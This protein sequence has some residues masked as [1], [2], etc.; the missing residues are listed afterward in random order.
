MLAA[1]KG[2]KIKNL[3]AMQPNLLNS[4]LAEIKIS[5]STTVKECDRRKVTQSRE[6]VE[7]FRE[8]FP[9]G[10]M[11]LRESFYIL[12]LNRANKILGYYRV[13]EGGLSGTVADPRLIFS[14]AL[15]C[16]A[17]SLIMAHNHP[18]GNIQPSAA[19]IQLTKNIAASGK[20]LEITVLDHIILTKESHYSFADEGL[21]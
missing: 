11:E 19:D 18:S 12:L 10:E 6:C 8:I 20:L 14:T 4:N 9:L 3:K 1:W 7:I 21:I 2:H 15:K 17:V 5:Y 13:S 16:N